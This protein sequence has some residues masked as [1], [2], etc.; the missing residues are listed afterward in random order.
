MFSQNFNTTD[1]NE[2]P[3]SLS[4]LQLK[5]EKI[6]SDNGPLGALLASKAF[7]QLAFTPIVGY[8]TELVGYN[9]TL[10]VG[11]W[12]MLAASIREYYKINFKFF[13]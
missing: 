13:S 11:S 12:N 6:E 8:L 2:G 5:Y 7:V 10:L 1:K 3:V 4:P 9:V